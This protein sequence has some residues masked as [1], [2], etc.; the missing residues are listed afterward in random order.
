M[1]LAARDQADSSREVAP[2]RPADDAVPIDTTGLSF[3]E[4]VDKIVALARPIF[5][6]P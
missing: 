5:G 6:R 4:Q 3:A 1:A 2:L